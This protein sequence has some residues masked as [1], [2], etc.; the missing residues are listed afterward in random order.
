MIANLEDLSKEGTDFPNASFNP[1]VNINYESGHAHS[2]SSP[3][4]IAIYFT[5]KHNKYRYY[6]TTDAKGRLIPLQKELPL[7]ADDWTNHLEFSNNFFTPPG[8]LAMAGG[9]SEGL[10]SRVAYKCTLYVWC[11]HSANHTD[12]W[13]TTGYLH[14]LNV[15]TVDHFTTECFC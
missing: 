10:P 13:I 4:N 11:T 7:P 3:N 1:V 8:M 9:G 14:G 5:G 12:S 6:V 15:R 2:A